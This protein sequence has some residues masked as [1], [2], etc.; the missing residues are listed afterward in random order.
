M[1]GFTSEKEFY[2]ST[3]SFVSGLP[4]RRYAVALETTQTLYLTRG[5]LEQLYTRISGMERL[6]RIMTE[7]HQVLTEQRA[8]LKEGKSYK[9][10]YL[11]FLETHTDI[12]NRLKMK[13]IAC[14]LNMTPGT[15]SHIRK[16]IM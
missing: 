16:E 11:N 5:D 9:Q 3:R 2:Y 8:E 7:R 4:S 15:L 12:S 6:V 14:Y 10:R 13:E 1:Y